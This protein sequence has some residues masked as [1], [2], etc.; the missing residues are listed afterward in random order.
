MGTKKDMLSSIFFYSL[1]TLLIESGEVK[2]SAKAG[3][4]E[5]ENRISTFHRVMFTIRF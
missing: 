5:N 2:N 4:D 1:I 3:G